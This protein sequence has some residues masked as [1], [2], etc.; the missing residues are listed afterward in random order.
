MTRRNETNRERNDT[1]RQRPERK[2]RPSGFRVTGRNSRRQSLNNPGAGNVGK[3][4][5]PANHWTLVTGRLMPWPRRIP[6]SVGVQTNGASLELRPRCPVPRPVRLTSSACSVGRLCIS[7]WEARGE[8][9]NDSWR[10]GYRLTSIFHKNY[11]RLN[12]EFQKK[13]FQTHREIRESHGGDP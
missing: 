4:G 9:N 6:D 12:F 8:S 1:F 13:H 5:G 11:L 2:A 7:P 3:P 10:E